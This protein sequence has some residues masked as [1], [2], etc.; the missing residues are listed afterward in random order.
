M[1]VPIESAIGGPALRRLLALVHRHTGIAMSEK[2]ST[3][4]QGRLRPRMRELGLGVYADYLE[5]VDRDPA[6]IRRFV[7]LVTTN[8]T[9]FFRTPRIWAYFTQVLLPRWHATHPERCMRIWSAAASTG[10]EAY[11]IAMVCDAFRTQHPSFDFQIAAS[12]I[13]SDV[14]AHAREGRYA[15]RSLNALRDAHPSEFARYFE[16]DGDG[17]RIVAAL[18]TRVR[19]FEHNLFERLNLREP[20]DVI[21]LRNVL[22]YF[23]L[24]DQQR[25]VAHMHSALASDGYLLLGES[26]SLSRM[27]MPFEFE[28][29][30]IY[31]AGADHATR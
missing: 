19:Y 8:E 3:L 31:R 18:R 20:F 21:F 14:L 12:D 24:A 1:D 2:K 17:A 30:L 16:T 27:T 4:L 13:A 6:E 9:A 7:N 26:E 22:I 5:V 28:L 25:V 11:T 29:P 10:E 15:G 23:D